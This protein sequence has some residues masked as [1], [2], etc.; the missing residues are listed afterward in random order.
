MYKKGIQKTTPKPPRFQ[1]AR[2]RKAGIVKIT[3]LFE[4][5]ARF[6]DI[7]SPARS[8]PTARRTKFNPLANLSN[9]GSFGSHALISPLSAEA[10]PAIVKTMAAKSEGGFHLIHPFLCLLTAVFSR[11]YV[12]FNRFNMLE[13]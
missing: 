9:R 3:L 1:A 12:I 5:L 7:C 10:L 8:S 4:N 13:T 6:A 11:R 2:K